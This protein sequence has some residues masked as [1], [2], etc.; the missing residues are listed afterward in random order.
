MNEYLTTALAAEHRKV[1][2]DEAHEDGL[3]RIATQGRPTF[4]SQLR[5]LLANSAGG[6]RSA[7]SA[8]VPGASHRLAH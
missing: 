2:L 3:A 1:L 5:H 7:G 4:W 6:R 8:T